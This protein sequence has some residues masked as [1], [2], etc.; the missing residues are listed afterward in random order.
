MT[1]LD[2]SKLLAAALRA[3]EDY[4]PP[5]LGTPEEYVR[6]CMMA[7]TVAEEKAHQEGLDA[8]QKRDR[9]VIQF[10][11]YMPT[12]DDTPSIKGYIACVAQGIVFGVFT[13]KEASQMLYA[14]Q[15]ALTLLKESEKKAHGRPRL[16]AR[17][18]LKARAA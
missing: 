13:G 17:R 7:M 15:V 8:V 6:R 14:G 12:L 10:K 2:R 4:P 5:R 1:N 18:G 9:L 3:A 16:T 11:L